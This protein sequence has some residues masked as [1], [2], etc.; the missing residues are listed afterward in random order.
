MD[1]MDKETSSI[2]AGIRTPDRPSP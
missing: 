2:L 1:I